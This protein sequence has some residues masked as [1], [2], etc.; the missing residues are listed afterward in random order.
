MEDADVDSRKFILKWLG[1]RVNIDLSQAPEDLWHYTDAYGLQGILQGEKLWATNVRFLNDS[2][3]VW[4]GV[5]LALG[6]LSDLANSLT[7]PETKRFLTGLS[8]PEKAII[9]K[10]LR[11]SLDAFVV[12]FCENGDLLS[13]WRAYAGSDSAGGYAIGFRPPGPFP[14]WAQSAPGGHGLKSP[15]RF[16]RHRRAGVRDA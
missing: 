4:H 3:E 2:Q 7:K 14:A 5:N 16:I 10:F 13:Q 11:D 9:P 1:E 6:A 8:D 15:A 12:C